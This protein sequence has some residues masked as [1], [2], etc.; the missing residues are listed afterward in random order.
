MADVD[1]RDG[2]SYSTA[3]ILEYVGRVHAPHDEALE[4]AF[5]ASTRT[6]LPAIQVGPNEGKLLGVLAR[7]ASAKRIVEVGTLAGYSGLWLA[8]A[9]P[10]D[11][12][13]YTIDHD[14]A[15]VEV[16]RET[17][18]R[19]GVADR[20]ELVNA[21]G[22]AGLAAIESHGPFDLMFIDADKGRYDRYGAWAAANLRQGGLLIAD[23]TFF[24]GKLL[25]PA[26]ASAAGVRRFHEAAARDFDSVSIPTPDGMVL[27]IRR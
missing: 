17:F 7:L 12:R 9:L 26:D 19:G 24:F 16:A 15:A 21:D 14:P 20:V 2:K 11:G 4:W 3:S 13:L 1:S 5:T 25:D 18:T 22:V 23:N 8:R 6:A 10:P 27:G